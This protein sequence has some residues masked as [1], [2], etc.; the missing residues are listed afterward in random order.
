M[1]LGF[2]RKPKEDA[3]LSVE[4][5]T[6]IP[7]LENVQSLQVR[8]FDPRLNTWVDKWTDN[9][10]LPRL[11]RLIIGRP[12]SPVPFDAIVPLGRTPL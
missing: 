11:V 1:A 6:W 4:R 12:D 2:V 3:A 7:L 10:T 5:E 9:L 8:Y